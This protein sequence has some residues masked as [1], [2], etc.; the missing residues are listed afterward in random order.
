MKRSTVLVILPVLAL[1]AAG[2]GGS[3]SSSD[4]G[5]AAPDDAIPAV[6]S[7]PAPTPAPTDAPADSADD[8][9][10][11]E[12]AGDRTV[13]VWVETGGCAQGGPNCARY[14]VTVD[15]TVSTTRDGLEVSAEPE[16]IGQVDPGLVQAWRDAVA[17]EDIDDLRSR[18]G[19]G[20]MT[21]AFDGTDYTLT[22]PVTGLE[23][24]SVE[25][26]FDPAEPAFA[27]AFALAGAAA[28]AA[29]LEF[30]MR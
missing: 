30:E 12:L 27:T 13:F 28:E 25:T 6:V 7:E 4:P 22:N 20:E 14:E 11:G 26:N 5:A 17:D 2:C 3:D 24:S 29:P 1:L 15:G 8:E 16:A 18:V 19:D 9:M 21:A 23:L 10:A